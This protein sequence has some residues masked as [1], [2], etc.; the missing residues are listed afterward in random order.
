MPSPQQSDPCKLKCTVAPLRTQLPQAEHRAVPSKMYPA[1]ESN[2]P[3]T[4]QGLLCSGDS[5]TS[6]LGMR[7]RPRARPPVTSQFSGFMTRIC[8]Q[9]LTLV[10][11]D[12]HCNVVRAPAL[13][14][15]PTRARFPACTWLLLPSSTTAKREV[16]SAGEC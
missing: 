9:D 1:I 6:H 5:V 7:H 16:T 11:R 4:G 15:P 10:R 12:L 8:N 2:L 14:N 13:A 3:L